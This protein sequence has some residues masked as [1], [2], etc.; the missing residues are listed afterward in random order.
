MQKKILVAG[1]L[2]VAVLVGWYLFMPANRNADANKPAQAP[3]ATV[4]T[5]SAKRMDVPVRLDAKGYVSSLNSVDIRPQVSNVIAKVHIKEGQFVKAGEMLFTLDDRAARVELQKAQAQIAKDKASLAD[6][7]RQLARSRE[8]L[9]KGFIAQSAVDTVQ[10]QVDAQNATLQSDGAAVEAARVLLSYQAIRAPSSGRAGVI[11][12]FTGSLVQPGMA[13]PMVTISQLHPSAATFTVP[14]AELNAVLAAQ[15]GAGLV[16]V[17]ALVPAANARIDGG[18]SFVDNAV[19]PQNGTIRV[20]A[21][22]PNENQL[23]WP[24]QYVALQTVVREIK[25]A[26][27]IPQAAIIVGVD[28]RTVYVVDA[29]KSAQPK[30]IELVYSFGDQAVVKGLEPGELVIVDGKQNLRPG[31]KVRDTRAGAGNNDRAA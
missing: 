12:V 16:K 3:A 13:T 28:A 9:S 23:L 10:A 17:A 21:V 6:L 29:N 5:V 27:V 2:L 30:R 26:I 31:M 14:E 19:D 11:N 24:G 4:T 22:F 15:K 8:L 7:Q 18:L 1:A 20:K 25:D